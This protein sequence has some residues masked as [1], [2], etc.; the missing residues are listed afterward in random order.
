MPRSPR[1]GRP[2]AERVEDPAAPDALADARPIHRTIMAYEAVRSVGPA[3]ASRPELV[4]EILR[5]F[6]AEGERIGADEYAAALEQRAELTDACSRWLGDFDALVTP[7]APAEAPSADGNGG[8]ALLHRMDAD[9]RTRRRPPER[10]RRRGPA[11]RSSARGRPGRRRGAPRHGEGGRASSRDQCSTVSAG[12]VS[13]ARMC[14]AVTSTAV[15]L[16][17]PTGSA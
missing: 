10:S 4:S 6:L 7:A 3:V 11:D 14:A 17:A 1:C 13:R 15:L 5:R 8:R 12:F 2:G 16:S 9:R